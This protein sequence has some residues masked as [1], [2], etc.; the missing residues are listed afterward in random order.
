[1][2][3]SEAKPGFSWSFASFQLTR[4]HPEKIL[5]CR[6][7]RCGTRGMNILRYLGGIKRSKLFTEREVITHS[8]IKYRHLITMSKVILIFFFFL[9][10]WISR[11]HSAWFNS[12]Y[13]SIHIVSLSLQHI[14]MANLLPL[15]P[16]LELTIESVPMPSQMV[17][18]SQETWR[19]KR[20]GGECYALSKS[21]FAAHVFCHHGE[22][23]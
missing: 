17:V 21:H 3:G 18:S 5:S 10:R 7:G 1:M 6:L 22:T 23:I 14:F 13:R 2:E 15:T 16:Q 4:L 12:I 20:T 11:W 19:R 8:R 9:L